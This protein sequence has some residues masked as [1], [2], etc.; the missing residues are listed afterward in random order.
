MSG[1]EL[2]EWFDGWW[3]EV[4]RVK[5]IKRYINDEVLSRL[6]VTRCG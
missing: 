4:K 3:G 6:P 2:F 5:E 1:F